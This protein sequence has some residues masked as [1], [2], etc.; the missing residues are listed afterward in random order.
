MQDYVNL[1][2]EDTFALVDMR[3]S[4]T[5]LFPHPFTFGNLG[6][7]MSNLELFRRWRFLWD[8]R[9]AT[10]QIYNDVR[11]AFEEASG[12]E[13][14]ATVA[15]APGSSEEARELFRNAQVI[16]MKAK[17]L[18]KHPFSLK[19]FDDETDEWIID[20]AK[21]F[22][23]AFG[24]PYIFTAQQLGIQPEDDNEVTEMV[25]GLLDAITDTIEEDSDDPASSEAHAAILDAISHARAVKLDKFL[26]LI[27]VNSLLTELA[28]R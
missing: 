15:I 18:P 11:D 10:R 25:D 14:G 23:A 1:S 28:A 17:P 24:Q 26:R 16:E 9:S 7:A 8:Y 20:Y 3:A 12:Y 21:V 2:A 4:D 22:D 27:G 19:D 13:D 6:M 5:E